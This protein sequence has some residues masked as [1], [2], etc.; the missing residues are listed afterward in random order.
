MRR[1]VRVL[2]DGGVLRPEEPRDLTPNGRYLVTTEGPSSEPRTEPPGMLDDLLG[3]V[4]DFGIS[5]LAAQHDHDLY[6]T[7]NQL[8]AWDADGYGRYHEDIHR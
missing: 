1:S 2:F 8:R 4:T 3:M 6:G 7:P 5:A